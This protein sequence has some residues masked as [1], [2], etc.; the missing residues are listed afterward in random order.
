MSLD[1]NA[2]AR[3]LGITTT[4]KPRRV[5][6]A[7][8]LPQRIAIVGQGSSAIS[9]S[10]EKRL[11][12]SAAQAGQVYGFGSPIHLVARQLLPANG[13]GVGTIPVTVYPLQDAG[14]G[15]APSVGSFTPSGTPAKASTMRL[16]VGGVRSLRFATPA[17]ALTGS[18]LWSLLSAAFA[19]CVAV[20]EMPTTFT[21]TYGSVTAGAI[22]GTGNG[23]L[24]ALSVL[25]GY[26]PQNGAWELECTALATNGGVFKLTSPAGVIV[27]SGLTMTPGV[28]IAT[29][30]EA[31]GLQFTLTDGTTDF[32][33]GAKFVITVPAPSNLEAT[34]KWEGDS[35]NDIVFETEDA[36]A[37]ITW[38][39][40]QPT[41][42]LL[43]PSVDSA[44]ALI[45]NVWETAGLS[46]LDPE[47]QDAL[48]AYQAFGEAR[49]GTLQHRPLVFFYG[50]TEADPETAT[51]LT[52]LR[53]TDR[54]TCQL[55]A[56]GS[57]ELPFVIAARQLA[58]IAVVANDDP[59]FDYGS[60]RANGISPGLENQQWDF[61]Q[62]DYAIKRGSSTS[63]IRNGEIY[64]KD[65]V[66][67]WRPDDEE[68]PGYRFVVDLQRLFTTIFNVEIRLK[69]PEWDGA[70][71]IPDDQPSK[72]ANAKR[73]RTA[74]ELIRATVDDLGDAAILA[75]PEAIKKTVEAAIVGPKRLRISFKPMNSGNTNQKDVL[76]D[77][78][79]YY[80][81]AAA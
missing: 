28:G 34:S 43:N 58:R 5:G 15:S 27:E 80:D 41:G 51:E 63:E 13:D 55:T 17:G 75:D 48:D 39:Y 7:A 66:T 22:S 57:K 59:A 14:G 16:K 50:N 67:P 23:T 26:A 3:V 33:V 73:P 77:W 79:F 70:P 18:A 37:D 56:P 62:C 8:L 1:P 53:S 30:F 78:D 49:W 21:L 42:G 64:I 46:C 35:A 71:M 11:L 47:D 45:G 74:K 81:P 12:N 40:V 24:T 20:A 19:A 10:S 31:G 54:V 32:G 60:Q 69:V 9:Y 2:V 76:I 65:V 61:T 72:N 4:Y 68:V 6:K 44:I 29:V 36:P 38:T 52:V 25:D